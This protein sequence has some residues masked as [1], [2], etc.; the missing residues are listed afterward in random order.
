M[1]RDPSKGDLVRREKWSGG[2][3]QYGLII[4]ITSFKSIFV[5][6]SG[7]NKLSGYC[8]KTVVPWGWDL[9]E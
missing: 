2:P 3:D 7:S 1:N 9:V 5:W 6:W 4:K 8:L